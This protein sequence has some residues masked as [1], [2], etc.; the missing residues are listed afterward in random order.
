MRP[1]RRA[2][3]DSGA[4]GAAGW[5]FAELALVLMV[6]AFAAGELAGPVAEPEVSPAA[7][8][9]T[10]ESEAVGCGLQRGTTK[11]LLE[12]AELTDP[13]TARAA[14]QA[15][16]DVEGVG[17]DERVGLALLFGVSENRENLE[18]GVER[19]QF[20]A[21]ALNEPRLAQLADWDFRTYLTSGDEPGS[22]EVELFLLECPA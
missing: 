1:R 16:L 2:A 22:V 9:Q 4:F 12:P 19:S 10:A 3:S 5:L 6:I 7:P 21:A 18:G 14:F 15:N 11:F 8:A 17:P 20:L 13:A